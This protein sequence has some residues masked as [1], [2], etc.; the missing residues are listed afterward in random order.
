MPQTVRQE[1]IL[2]Q[3]SQSRA[4]QGIK[5]TNMATCLLGVVTPPGTGT[6][7][8]EGYAQALQQFSNQKWG[9]FGPRCK[10]TYD[11]KD[12]TASKHL[13]ITTKQILSHHIINS[14]RGETARW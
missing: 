8:W 3:V 5:N 4:C 9:P 1:S 11:T 14:W 10:P 13:P 2:T 6:A 12:R 7:S